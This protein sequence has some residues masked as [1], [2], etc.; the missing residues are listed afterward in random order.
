M[1]RKPR[2]LKIAFI[3]RAQTHF[4]G[5]FFFQEFV[6]LLQLRDRLS[7][8]MRD[9]RSH[10]EY[11]VSQ[12]VLALLYPIVLGLARL[13]AASFLRSN[14][15]FQY[16]TG[17]P[18]FPHPSTL[19]RF[20]YDTSK[21]ARQQFARVIDRLTARLLQHPHPR[22][23]LVLDLDSTSLLV[24]G[25]HEG[26]HYVY[27][28]SRRGVR[29]YEPLICC[30]ANSGL[31]W[32]GELRPGGKPGADE[33]IPFLEHAFQ[34][35]PDSVREVR[36]RADAGFYSDETLTWLE[37]RG[38][39]YAVVARLTRPLQS[40]LAAAAY[41]SV[42]PHWALAEI[43]YQATGWLR[44]RRI[45]AVRKQLADTDPQPTLFTVGRY[46]YHAFVTNLHVGPE[47]V[48]RFYNDRA[49]LELLIKELKYDYGLGHVP[50]RR[51]NANAFSFQILR[52]AY[53]L[54]LGFQMLCLPDRWHRATLATIRNRFFLL[55]A[56]LA[57]PQGRPVLRFSAACPARDDCEA[58]LE[59][60]HHLDGRFTW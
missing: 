51:F 8:C 27:N 42:S 55:P 30:E 18:R 16:L 36:I 7:R 23:R 48:W 9:C 58:V 4:G 49:T 57:K 59:A 45:I 46:A 21:Q 11:S 41:R 56:V 26:A 37:D 35:M 13:E 50:T 52:L 53:N 43:P 38:A 47:R 1:R 40:R 54:V 17:L 12:V 25:Q 32:A 6:T 60:L 28:P 3:D 22:S 5:L 14:G 15:I 33:V 24:Y 20:L 31:F 34:I 10:N 44:E 29:S 2:N 39:Q 19:R